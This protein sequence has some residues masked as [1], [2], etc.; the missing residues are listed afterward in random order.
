MSTTHGARLRPAGSA[1]AL[2]PR[3]RRSLIRCADAQ[4]A[5]PLAAGWPD[6]TPP[7]CRKWLA[8]LSSASSGP[9]DLLSRLERGLR[10]QDRA[11]LEHQGPGVG[12]RWL[13]PALR[14]RAA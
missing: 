1:L 13:R 8:L 10:D 3:S 2:L 9:A 14:R 5:H 12:L 11:R 6:R 4:R 7:D